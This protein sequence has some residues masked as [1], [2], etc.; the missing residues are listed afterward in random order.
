MSKKFIAFGVVFVML[1]TLGVNV[2]AVNADVRFAS[3]ET[4]EMLQNSAAG[5]ADKNSLEAAPQGQS[6]NADTQAQQQNTNQQAVTPQVTRTMDNSEAIVEQNQTKN[7]AMMNEEL[8]EG[9]ALSRYSSTRVALS[10][11]IQGTKYEEAAEVLGALGIMV[12]D[13]DTGAFRPDDNILRSEMAK[14]AVYSVGLEDIAIGS[15]VVTR[16]PDVA[17]NHWAN[18]AINVAEQQGLVIGDDMGTFRPDDP[19]LLQE[20]VTILVRALGYEPVAMQRCGYP[21]GYMAVA[22]ENQLLKGISALGKSPAK[23]GDI[24]QLT[25]NALTINLMEQTGF[26]SSVVYEVV[27]KTL[28]FDRLNVE[29]AY[30]QITGTSETTLTGGST[31]A[32]DRVMINN[33]TFVEGNTRAREYLGYNVVYYARINATTDEKTLILVRPQDSKNNELSINAKDLVSVTGDTDA[34][35]TVTYWRAG[36]NDSTTRTATIVAE[37]VYIYN[38]KFIET[39]TNDQLIPVTGNLVLLDTDTNNVYDIVFVNHFTNLVVESVSTVTGRVTD[40]YNNGSLLLDPESTDVMFT[41][42]K[43]GAEIKPAELKEWNVVSYTVSQDKQLIKAYVSTES[44]LGRVTQVTKDGFKINDSDT[45]YKKAANYPNDINLRDEGRFYLD[46]EGNVAAVDQTAT[47]TGAAIRGAYGYLT[48]AAITGTIDKVLQF[49]V[50]TAAGE[51][52]TYDGATK[53]RVNNTYGLTPAEALGELGKDGVVTPQLITYEVNSQGKLTGLDLA[54]DNTQTGAVNKG[55]FTK[56]IAAADQVY[57]SASGMLGNVKV[58]ADTIVFDIPQEAGTDTTRYSVRN[59]SM[60]ANNTPYDIIVYDLKEDFSAGAIIVTSTTGITEAK[61]P[62]VLVDEVASAQ[63][64]DYDAIDIVYGL[65]NSKQVELPSTDKNV[66]VK[67]D[68]QTLEQGDV[69][70]YSTNAKGEVDKITL[71][72]DRDAKATEFTNTIGTDLTT[73]YGRVT[74]KFSDSINVS[75][76]GTVRNYSTTGATVYEYNSQRKTGNISVVTAGDIEVFEE[77][78][79]VRVFIKIFEDNVSEIVIVR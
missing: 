49:R 16:F 50:F 70:Q 55:V 13:A 38:G 76:N 52:E 43:N 75:V 73:V 78:N 58:T 64:E 45:I 15:N 23:R 56:N 22:S 11:D 36:T 30:G 25:F 6:G 32:E 67:G 33:Q 46:I 31:T 48:D 17:S 24:A 69:F 10:P 61:S 66:F 9:T 5:N 18:G 77:G 20:A 74:K 34:N 7:N 79:E 39:L 57:K 19:V 44:V 29:K 35:K 47:S 37:P 8:F 65:E 12:G 68:G 53:I 51:T 60:F 1:F 59:S 4:A 2:F 28:L 41:L 54:V 63:N 21:A 72:F 62:I 40:K 42:I 14:V 3:G 26:G 71:L 27:D